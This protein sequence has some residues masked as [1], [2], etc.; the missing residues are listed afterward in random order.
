MFEWRI[1]LHT[2]RHCYRPHTEYVGGYCFH[3]VCKTVHRPPTSGGGECSPTSGR[4][5]PTSGGASLYQAG[6]PP[7]IRHHI[8]WAP[9]NQAPHQVG[10]PL[11]Q[12]PHK[13]GPLH[14]APH[15]AGGTY[16][17]HSDRWYT[18][19]GHAGGLSC[20][21]A[22]TVVWGKVMVS[23][24]LFTGGASDLGLEGPPPPQDLGLGDLPLLDLGLG[25]P[26][27]DLRLDRGPPTGPET[28]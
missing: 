22:H 27:P 2:R 19:G 16:I 13:V 24:C 23:V 26:S 21:C 7:Y 15:Q 5:T 28:G 18:S 8:R 12:A 11:H 1:W 6:E 3:F 9:L 25:D 14:Q 17:R 4:G 20:Y 10:A